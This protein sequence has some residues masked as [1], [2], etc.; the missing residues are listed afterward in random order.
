MTRKLL[1]TA[2]LLF[3]PVAL[4][5]AIDPE[6]QKAID[7]AIEVNEKAD[8]MGFQWRDAGKFIKQAQK[9]AE[10]GDKKKALQ[11]AEKARIQGEL[12]IEQAKAQANAG[13]RF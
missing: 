5:Q 10:S 1:L 3:G 6:V 12:A 7:A 11:L 4:A 9:A 13:P 8:K 2:L